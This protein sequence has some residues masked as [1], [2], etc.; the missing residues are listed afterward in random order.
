MISKLGNTAL[1]G[2]QRSTQGM[3]RSAVEI[4]RASRPGDQ[5]NM[6]RAM[7]ELKQHEQAAARLEAA[8]A[9]AAGGSDPYGPALEALREYVGI[10]LGLNASAL[11]FADARAPL[12]AR[13][14][15]AESL[16]ALERVFNTCEA[17][18]YSGGASSA[19]SASEFLDTVRSTVR[20]LDKEIGS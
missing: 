16:A 2:L 7:V 19:A 9:G 10:K 6:T 11:T 5:S 14:A 13:G 3:T 18:R 4:A 15:S 20:A 12:A 1:Q 8:L 17:H